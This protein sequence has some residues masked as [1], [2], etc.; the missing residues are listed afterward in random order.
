MTRAFALAVITVAVI[1]LTPWA[2][3]AA[4]A[5]QHGRPLRRPR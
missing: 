4:P 5:P 1:N 3:L 2:L